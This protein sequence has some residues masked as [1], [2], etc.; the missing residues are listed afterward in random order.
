MPPNQAP[1]RGAAPPSAGAKATSSA[2]R[3][4]D[5]AHPAR[6]HLDQAAKAVDR[7]VDVEV[8]GES[9]VTKVSAPVV[10]LE[11]LASTMDEAIAACR[12]DWDLIVA[13]PSPLRAEVL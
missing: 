1:P 4:A 8:A 2:L 11:R 9:T 10:E 6:E 12:G 5:A 7:Y 13:V 3:L